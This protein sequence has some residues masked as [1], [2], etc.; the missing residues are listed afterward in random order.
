MGAA[1]AITASA[2]S[3]SIGAFGSLMAGE[4]AKRSAY[5]QASR[6]EQFGRDQLA[7]LARRKELTIATQ[8]QSFAARGVALSGSPLLLAAETAALAERDA[9]RIRSD[10]NFQ[11][12]ELRRYGKQA[13]TSGYLN[14]LGSLVGAGANVGQ[15]LSIGGSSKSRTLLTGAD[16]GGL[17]GGL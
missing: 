9:S 15:A 5:A 3:G 8:R 10:V 13:Q 11:S 7:D 17:Y 12:Y 2:V 4:E 6:L 14:A 16:A 1:A